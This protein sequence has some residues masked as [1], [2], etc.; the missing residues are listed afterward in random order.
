[1]SKISIFVG[2]G[3]NFAKSLENFLPPSYRQLFVEKV[4]THKN[5]YTVK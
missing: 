3:N 4:A 1:M 2:G 5:T